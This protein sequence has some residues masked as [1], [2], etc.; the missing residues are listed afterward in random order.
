MPEL[1]AW[2]ELALPYY[3]P[4]ATNRIVGGRFFV[5]GIPMRHRTSA[6]IEKRKSG[7]G[8]KLIKN[9]RVGHL[10]EQQIPNAPFG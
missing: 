9:S 7:V 5:L 8:P 3:Q 2:A 6:F 4:V 1:G 10:V